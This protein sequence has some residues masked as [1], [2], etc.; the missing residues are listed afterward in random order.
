MESLAETLEKL[1]AEKP[2]DV[3]M[4]LALDAYSRIL[5]LDAQRITAETLSSPDHAL[6]PL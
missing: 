3:P 2:E 5:F 4:Q 6:R 1:K